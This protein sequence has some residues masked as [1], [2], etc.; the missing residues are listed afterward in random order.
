MEDYQSNLRELALTTHHN[1]FRSQLNTFLESKNIGT[2][3]TAYERIDNH[4]A[5]YYEDGYAYVDIELTI[6]L[7]KNTAD[8]IQSYIDIDQMGE[9]FNQIINRL[10]SLIS[11]FTV[12]NITYHIGEYVKPYNVYYLEATLRIKF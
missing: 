10:D 2:H 12:D 11:N 4:I 6:D 5:K 9:Y 3:Q 8:I 7:T 1:A